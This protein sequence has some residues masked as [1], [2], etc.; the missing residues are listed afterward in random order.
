MGCIIGEYLILYSRLHLFHPSERLSRTFL[1]VIIAEP[2]FIEFPYVV[3]NIITSIYPQSQLVRVLNV[4]VPLE[5][6]VWGLVDAFLALVYILQVKKLWIQESA[7][8]KIRKVLWRL[9]F[10]CA[11]C[12]GANVINT[13]VAFA[14]E[15]R[16]LVLSIS[17][18]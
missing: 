14:M 10:M 15:Q 4:W 3:M 2:L 6:L 13:T 16:D 7:D 18:S 8:P 17:V 11:I 5:A 1:V 12:F 9:I